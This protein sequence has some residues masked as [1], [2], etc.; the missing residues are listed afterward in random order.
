MPVQG[1]VGG[2]VWWA[3]LE[4]DGA[5]KIIARLPFVE[6]EDH[7][8]GLPVFAIARHHPDGN[9]DCS[10]RFQTAA[11][12]KAAGRTIRIAE[13]VPVLVKRA[14]GGVKEGVHAGARVLVAGP[15]LVG[16]GG[17]LGG[18]Q[19]DNLRFHR[20]VPRV[21][22]IANEVVAQPVVVGDVVPEFPPVVRYGGSLGVDQGDLQR[23]GSRTP[24]PLSYG[25]TYLLVAKI[26]AGSAN[27]DQ[28]FMRVYG[29][30]EPI[31][32]DEPG[33]WSGVGPPLY[34]NL[35]FGWLELHI[36]SKTRQ[37]IDELRVGETWSSVTAPWRGAP[38]S[39]SPEGH[40]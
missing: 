38:P 31:E 14:I 19:P 30:E 13:D 9:A 2:G 17:R 6:R 36:N 11:P 16:V 27:A 25:E 37:T 3:A 28:V 10:A 29:P 34:S 15:A 22:T 24:L 26:V 20:V 5:P 1:T 21:S 4:A 33:S 18:Y 32:R 35:V 40:W 8:A 23:V 12:E 39:S 7:P